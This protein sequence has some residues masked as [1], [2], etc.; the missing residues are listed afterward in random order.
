M[1]VRTALL[2]ALL[3]TVPMYA[4]LIGDSVTVNWLY[5]NTSS[6]VGSSTVTV[7][8]GVEITCPGA[9]PLCGAFVGGPLGVTIDIADMSILLTHVATETG[10][11]YTFPV[12]FNG[13]EFADLDLGGLGIT[14][15]ALTTTIAGLDASRVTFGT[16]FIRVDMQSFYFVDGE[17]FRLDLQSG[18]IPE[19]STTLLLGGGLLALAG[20]LRRRVRF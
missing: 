18:A 7:G 13:W 16:D 11:Y 12:A 10:Y 2:I 8:G 19:P 17:Y 3:C 14:G 15:F 6:V 1:K 9:D 20:L 4:G 5:P